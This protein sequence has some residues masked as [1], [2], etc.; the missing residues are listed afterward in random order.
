M[1][2]ELT[3]KEY[4]ERVSSGEAVP[5]GGSVAALTGALSAA[6]SR[7]VCLL[8]TDRGQGGPDEHMRALATIASDLGTFL[9]GAVDAD[10]D[11]YLGV[12]TAYRMAKASTEEAAARTA[13]IQEALKQAALVPLSVAEACAA[14]ME[15]A[16]SVIVQGNRNALS[17]GVV[18]A[19]CARTGILGAL[20]NVR[21]NLA[22]IKDEVFCDSMREKAAAL[23]RTADE[24]ERAA[25]AAAP[26]TLDP[27]KGT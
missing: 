14:L 25:L 3:V 2:T 20:W 4:L 5:G 21:V 23:E 12:V 6:L 16:G 19:L 18:A 13:A 8:T 10:A 22:S 27:G 15:V 26:L 24:G 11:A 9:T 7:M 1:L 17:D